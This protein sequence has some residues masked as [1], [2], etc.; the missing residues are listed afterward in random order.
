MLPFVVQ[1]RQQPI[2]EVIGTDESGKIE[3][4]RRGYLTT[5]EKAWVQQVQQYDDGSSEIVT[6]SRN[7][8]RKFGMGMDHAYK[9]VLKI[10]SGTEPE[11]PEEV[12]MVDAI[13]KQFAEDLTNVVKGL[14]MGQAKQE[15]VYAAC[16]LQY[17]VDSN[18][19]VADINKVH[20]DLVQALAQL[21]RDEESR[22]LEAFQSTQP[23]DEE[24][25]PE[26]SLEEKEKKPEKPSRTRSRSTSGA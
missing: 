1:P 19:K 4:E 9:L 5:G 14:A 22:S 10:I 11:K 26:L 2:T 3:I 18:F 6:V 25:P 13:E 24:S 7:V 21:Y 16:M 15:L 23:E 17:R 8:A 12:E 20:P